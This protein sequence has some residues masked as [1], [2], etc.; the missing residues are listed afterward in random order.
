MNPIEEQIAKELGHDRSKPHVQF[1][2]HA[3]KNA[4]RSE[5]A[6]RAKYDA[7]VYILKTPT[8]PDLVVRNTFSRKMEEKDKAEFPEA[9]ARYQARKQQI[10]N[11]NPHV[12]GIP[13]MTVTA[14][15]ELRDLGIV[16]CRD[17]VGYEGDLDDLEPLREIALEVLDIGARIRARKSAYQK[18]QTVP[19]VQVVQD[20]QTF[21]YAFNV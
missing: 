8:A 11:Y 21:H 15:A 12:K 13:G 1:Y 19:A 20:G 10:D 14:N 4:K 5:E 6:G 17:L 9:W 3:V 16:T 18:P 2:D 7:Q